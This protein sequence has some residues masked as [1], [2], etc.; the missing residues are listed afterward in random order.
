MDAKAHLEAFLESQT[1]MV[2]TLI[3]WVNDESFVKQAV[4]LD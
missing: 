4:T 1:H 2:I 3:T